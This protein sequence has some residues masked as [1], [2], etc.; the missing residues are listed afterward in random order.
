MKNIPI[1]A[2]ISIVLGL[3]VFVWPHLIPYLVPLYMII[4]G[5]AMIVNKR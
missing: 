5:V 3:V 2:L 4:S 1:I